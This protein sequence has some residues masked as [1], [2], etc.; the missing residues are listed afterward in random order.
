[1]PLFYKNLTTAKRPTAEIIT[2]NSSPWINGRLPISLSVRGVRLTP[3]RKSVTVIPAFARFTS[4]SKML[5]RTIGGAKVR[6]AAAP[7]NKK[8]N[9]GIADPFPVSFSSDLYSHANRRA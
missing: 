6:I 4:E 1:G 7:I 2:H 3:I 8:M 9:H 5:G